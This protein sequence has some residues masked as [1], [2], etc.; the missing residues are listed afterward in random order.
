ML[1]HFQ[2]SDHPGLLDPIVKF[3]AGNL[4]HLRS[5]AAQKMNFRRQLAQGRDERGA[6]IIAARFAG[7]EIEFYHVARASRLRGSNCRLE[8]CAILNPLRNFHRQLQRRCR[9]KS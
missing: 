8:A 1:D 5:A 9:L 7:D 4:L 6:V 2:K 3:W